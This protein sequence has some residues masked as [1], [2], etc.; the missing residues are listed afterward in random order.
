MNGRINLYL[1][2][3][4]RTL[5]AWVRVRVLRA[6]MVKPLRRLDDAQIKNGAR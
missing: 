3:D 2:T 1:D 5:F 6:F 4:N